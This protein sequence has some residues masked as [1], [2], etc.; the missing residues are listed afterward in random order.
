MKRA[1]SSVFK[2]NKLT[3]HLGCYFSSIIPVY[4]TGASMPFA[5]IIEN[6]DVLGHG[7]GPVSGSMQVP[8]AYCFVT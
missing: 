2:V 3:V 1:G 7:N 4:L 5:S 6:Q 8:T